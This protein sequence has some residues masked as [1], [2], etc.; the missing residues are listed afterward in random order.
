MSN[1]T[2][3]LN[4][5]FKFDLLTPDNWLTWKCRIST[6]M[7]KKKLL[8]LIEGS[9]TTLRK[10]PG[11]AKETATAVELAEMAAWDEADGQACKIIELSIGD[12]EMIHISSAVTAKKMWDQLKLVKEAHG[13]I[14]VLAAQ[15][16]FYR[17]YV[18]EGANIVEHI[19]GFRKT[20]E[21]IHMM[22]SLVAD[23]DFSLL[24]LPSLPESWDQFTSAYLGSH[25]S[26]SNEKVT[27]KS[28]ELIAILLE[29]N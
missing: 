21:E 28:H 14:V 12:K 7:C 1:A 19:T 10:R 3:I 17:L 9:E 20:Q 25:S 26:T 5:L 11:Q 22:G 29:E 23:E 8:N 16:K 15:R 4:L 18:K 6:M 2:A 27:V 24:L 13:H